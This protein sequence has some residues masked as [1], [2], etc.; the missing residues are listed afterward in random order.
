[1]DET[2]KHMSD[3]LIASRYCDIQFNISPVHEF[4]A[5]RYSSIYLLHK[6]G[7]AFERTLFIADKHKV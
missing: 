4:A 2:Y 5:I 1:M 3:Q 6:N 7:T